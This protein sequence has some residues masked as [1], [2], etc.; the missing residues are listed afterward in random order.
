MLKW[1]A[2]GGA[3]ALV[4]AAVLQVSNTIRLAAMARRREIGIMRLVGAS[5]IYIQLPFVLE[6]VFSAMVGAALACMSIVVVMQGFVSLVAGPAQDLAVDR[7][8]RRGLVDGADRGDRP[9]AGRGSDTP[10][11][12]EIPQSLS[13]PLLQ[14]SGQRHAHMERPRSYLIRGLP[15]S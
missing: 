9:R 1:L 7:L 14:E 6:V 12:A 8:V 2:I 10:D 13:Q 11:D 5:S 15:G 3:A 4:F